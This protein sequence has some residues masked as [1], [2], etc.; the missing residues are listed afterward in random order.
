[1]KRID[2]ILVRAAPG[3]VAVAACVLKGQAA[4]GSYRPRDGL[5]MLDD[6]SPLWASDHRAVLATLALA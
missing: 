2:Y 5:G 4:A 3:D 6:D 1:V